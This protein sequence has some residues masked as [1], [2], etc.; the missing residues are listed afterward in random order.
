MPHDTLSMCVCGQA[1]SALDTESEALV[2]EALARSMAGR[3]TIVVAHRLSTIRAATSIAVVQACMLCPSIPGDSPWVAGDR[4]PAPNLVHTPGHHT[5]S[6][7]Q[8]FV[9]VQGKD[10]GAGW[11]NRLE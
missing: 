11:R 3:T 6:A 8:K 10:D 2:Q 7:G 5:L 9:Q 4:Q 1:T